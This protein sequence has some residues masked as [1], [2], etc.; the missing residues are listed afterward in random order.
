MIIIKPKANK[1]KQREKNQID[2]LYFP[3]QPTFLCTDWGE[4]FVGKHRNRMFMTLHYT[5]EVNNILDLARKFDIVVNANG[6]HVKCRQ[7]MLHS[8][9]RKKK[10]GGEEINLNS[11]RP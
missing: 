9:K 7:L 2:F 6:K 3:T 10:W 1:N 11:T 4:G 5:A 8:I